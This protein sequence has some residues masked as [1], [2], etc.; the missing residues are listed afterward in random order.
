MMASPTKTDL[1]DRAGSEGTHVGR[2][3]GR[4]VGPQAERGNSTAFS[5]PRVTQVLSPKLSKGQRAGE[6]CP[7]Q[8]PQQREED[9][10]PRSRHPVFA[11]WLDTPCLPLSL[12]LSLRIVLLPEEFLHTMVGR[13]LHLFSSPFKG[14][15]H[16]SHSFLAG[17]DVGRF[18]TP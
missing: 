12:S 11:S 5:S 14:E 1:A 8:D 13:L 9:S 16:L 18:P 4:V 17:F 2:R 6:A 3:L 10:F 15:W 7:G